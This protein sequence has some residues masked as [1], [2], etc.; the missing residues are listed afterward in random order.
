AG[1]VSVRAALGA[2][3]VL[4]AAGLGVAAAVRWAFFALLAGY[5]VLMVAYTL[6][7][8]HMAV[9]DIAVVASGFIVRLVAGGLAVAVAIS[10]WFLIRAAVRSVVI[11]GGQRF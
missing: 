10:R 9:L 6:W 7:L 8:K 3:A 5:V 1:L 2:A 4:L 11:V